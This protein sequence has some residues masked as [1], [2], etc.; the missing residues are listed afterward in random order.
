MLLFVGLSKWNDLLYLSSLL[1]TCWEVLL[2][3]VG[4]SRKNVGRFW[5]NVGDFLNYLRRFFC[6]VGENILLDG[7]VFLLDESK[8]SGG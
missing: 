2:K 3:N 6:F 5:K 8:V 1:F 4:D 7:R